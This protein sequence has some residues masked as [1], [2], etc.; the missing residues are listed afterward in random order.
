M[1]LIGWTTVEKREDADRLARGLVEARLV[2]CAQI[3]GPITSHYI[4][5]N[6]A[7]TA[8]EFRLMIKFLPARSAAVETWLMAHHPYATAE[9]VVVRAEYVAEKYLSWARANCSDAPLNRS[10]PLF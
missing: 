1:L 5:E 6:H 10:Q 2:A 8:E 9:W 7:E 3:E 4:W